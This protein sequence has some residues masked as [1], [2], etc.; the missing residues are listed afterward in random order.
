MRHLLKD[1]VLP[2]LRAAGLCGAGVRRILV[3]AHGLPESVAGER[4]ADLMGEDRDPLVGITVADG[5]L[6]VCVSSLACPFHEV[7]AVALLV[8]ARLGEAVFGRDSASLEQAVQDLLR[9]RGWRLAI[10]ESMTGGLVARL[11]TRVAGASSVFV[12]GAVT[13]SN[14]AKVRRLGVTEES[15]RRHGAVSDE[16]AREMALGMARSAGVEVA[17]GIT[18]IAGPTGA[19]AQKPVGLVFIGLSVLGEVTSHRV[20]IQGDREYIQLRA[21]RVALDLLRRAVRA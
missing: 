1:Q 14:E 10:A 6:T 12:E 19:T 11:L 3:R 15:L 5:V 20:V 13:Y 9:G 2:R 21:A 18:G 16:V 4:I 8:E 7:E 17:A